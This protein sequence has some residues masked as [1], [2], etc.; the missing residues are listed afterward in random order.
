MTR[1]R[2]LQADWPL[3]VR[4]LA[5]QIR[6]RPFSD[7][8]SNGFILDRVR[9]DFLEARYVER[10]EYD[11]TVA[12]PFGKE[13]TFRRLEFHQTSFRAGPDWPGLELVDAPRSTQS[14]VNQL[15]EIT[16]FALPVAPLTVDVMSWVNDFQKHFGSRVV[17]DSIQLGAL[18]IEK[19][20]RAKVVLKGEED[21]R[22]ACKELIAG[23]KHVLEKLQFRAE[24]G[25]LRATVLLA[26]NASVKIDG[27]DLHDEALDA[28]RLSLPKQSSQ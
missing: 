23:R 16:D 9:D 11:E 20:V 4:A 7:D 27:T 15:L 1:Y 12:D 3:P 19:G 24:Q 21:V 13:L 10:Y 2:W 17:I 22:S 14:L 25:H 18:Q 26:N 5:K 6:Q 8:G 28:L